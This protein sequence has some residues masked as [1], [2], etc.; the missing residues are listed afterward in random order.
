[1]KVVVI[2]LEK[3]VE[4]RERVAAGLRELGLEFELRNA[5][6]GQNV[7]PEISPWQAMIE[8]VSDHFRS[9]QFVPE[10]SAPHEQKMVLNAKFCRLKNQQSWRP[11]VI[12]QTGAQPEKS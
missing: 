5:V 7:P 11:I 9:A 8:M 1:M 3:V 10:T 2:S 4:R 6:D 12:Q